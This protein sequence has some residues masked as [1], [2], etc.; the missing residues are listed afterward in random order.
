[1][2]NNPEFS[3]RTLYWCSY[4]CFFCQLTYCFCDGSAV[5]CTLVM[6]SHVPCRRDI[7]T[8]CHCRCVCSRRLLEAEAVAVAV[9]FPRLMSSWGKDSDRPTQTP[10]APVGG[11]VTVSTAS[12]GMFMHWHTWLSQYILHVQ[13]SLKMCTVKC[14]NIVLLLLSC[15][16][17]Y[18]AMC[19]L[20]LGRVLPRVCCCYGECCHVC[21][22]ARESVAT[23]V[24]LLRRVLPCVYCC[25]G[26]CCHVWVVA[27]D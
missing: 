11:A 4:L 8:K 25:Y 16:C 26:E 27:R 3:Y 18:V 14:V 22:V 19:E 17:V 24:L 1:M 2:Y 20:L 10:Q 21:I 15:V 13:Q 5:L 7:V 9:A 6:W 23:C 12:S